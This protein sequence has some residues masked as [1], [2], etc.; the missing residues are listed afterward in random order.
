MCDRILYIC[1]HMIAQSTLSRIIKHSPL[2]TIY[3]PR[4]LL[5]ILNEGDN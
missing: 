4:I 3:K 1:P 5:L 2:T